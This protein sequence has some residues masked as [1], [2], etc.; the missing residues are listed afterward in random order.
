[1]RLRFAAVVVV[2]LVAAG[3]LAQETSPQPRPERLYLP[4]SG[5]LL[6]STRV[7][8]LGGAYVGVAEGVAGFSANLAA[9]AHRAPHLDRPWDVGF[10]L[11][12]LD[13]PFVSPKS[14][15]LDNDGV[16]DEAVGTSQFLGGLMLQYKRFGIGWHFRWTV[17]DYCALSGLPECP[18]GETIG[19]SLTNNAL[20]GA[21]ALGRDDFIA[22]I[23]LYTANA[24]FTHHG[25]GRDYGGAGLEIDVLYRPHGL[26]YRVGMSVKPQV[27]AIYRPKPNDVVTIA[28]RQI[29]SGMVSP[30]VASLGGSMRFGEGSGNYNRLS[31]AA[32]R[33]VLDRFGEAWAPPE[34]PADAAAGEWLLTGQ[35]DYISAT[36]NTVPIS[37]FIDV[38]VATFARDPEVIGQHGYLVP[39]LGVEH[40]TISNRLRTRMGLFVE[41]SPYTDRSPRPH[42]TGGLDLFLFEYWDK[43]A[44]TLCFDFARLYYNVGVSVGFWR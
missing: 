32:R 28:D 12:Y 3:A 20:A 2:V 39:H 18:R 43:W 4:A 29:Y 16:R 24:S 15:D 44:L 22:A 7:I 25:G 31:P 6:G 8:G 14:R 36:E 21:V 33:D 17:L 19:V 11:S 34:T 42:I 30:A 13:V 27:V 40:E 10:T 23:G 41:P 38:E 26:N 1:V 9:L 37:S 35:V 5:V